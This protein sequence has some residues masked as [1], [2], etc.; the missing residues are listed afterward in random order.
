MR[1]I[2]ILFIAIA[3]KVFEKLIDRPRN[4]RGR[5]R[6]EDARLQALE[7]ALDA[8]TPVDSGGRA[9]ETSDAALLR[10]VQYLLLLRVDER[11]AD[12]QG[13]GDCS[14]EATSHSSGNDVCIRI[15]LALAIHDILHELVADKVNTLKGDVHHQSGEVAAI[16]GANAFRL[17]DVHHA[18]GARVVR[19]VVHLHSLFDH[20]S[21]IHHGVV[22][23]RGQTAGGSVSQVGLL[24][25]LI[26]AANGFFHLFVA[27]VVE[28][29]CWSGAANDRRNALDWSEHAFIA[30]HFVESLRH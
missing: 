23:K 10:S 8:A 20:F 13:S 3:N 15:V 7:V 29:V 11:F 27:R 25:G 1:T 26:G 19:T 2:Q 12:V 4:G 9:D 18:G 6:V 24:V 5:H 14:G 30:H 21:R 28:G 22:K 16:K 17:K